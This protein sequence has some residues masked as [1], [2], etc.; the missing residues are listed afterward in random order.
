MHCSAQ[1]VQT[2]DRCEITDPQLS[3]LDAT[4]QKEIVPIIE[5]TKLKADTC[6]RAFVRSFFCPLFAFSLRI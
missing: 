5:R 1:E 2:H 6:Q 4:E 3:P